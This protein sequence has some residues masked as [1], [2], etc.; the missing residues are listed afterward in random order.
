MNDIKPFSMEL[1]QIENSRQEC[2]RLVQKIEKGLGKTIGLTEEYK[3]GYYE[4]FADALG[5]I[6]RLL[7]EKQGV[8]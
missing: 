1:E 5:R 6:T 7:E 3:I 8:Q 4:G 2:I